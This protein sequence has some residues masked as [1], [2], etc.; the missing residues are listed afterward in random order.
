MSHSAFQSYPPQTHPANSSSSSSLLTTKV[1]VLFFLN[2]S[3]DR[4][5]GSLSPSHLAPEFTGFNLM[6][7]LYMRSQVP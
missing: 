7:E 6:Q 1:Y 3:S 5:G 4:D 2:S